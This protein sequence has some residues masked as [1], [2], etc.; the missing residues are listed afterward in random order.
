MNLSSDRTMACL[1]KYF[2]IDPSKKS[3]DNFYEEKVRVS[4]YEL[5][6]TLLLLNDSIISPRHHGKNAINEF[7]REPHEYW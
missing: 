6:Q 4:P 3:R 1:G 5:V 7:Q 2:T